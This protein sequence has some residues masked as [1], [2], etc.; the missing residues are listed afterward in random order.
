M[1]SDLGLYCVP[2]TQRKA[3]GLYGF[4]VVF[5][6]LFLS[7]LRI[8]SRF[9]C[10]TVKQ[11]NRKNNRKG[12]VCIT[13]LRQGFLTFDVNIKWRSETFDEINVIIVQS[14]GVLNMN[15]LYKLGDLKYN[16]KYFK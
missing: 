13:R 8:A 2:V 14:V 3:L 16:G 6:N 1:A 10:F 15:T 9:I 4:A 7:N 11:N 12:K 5:F